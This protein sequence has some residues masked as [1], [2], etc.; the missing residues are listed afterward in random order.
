MPKRRSPAKR[1]V[2]ETV[3]NA[4]LKTIFCI[5]IVIQA[6]ASAMLAISLARLNILQP[7]QF[8]L[9]LVVLLLFLGFNIFKLLVSKRSGRA[10]KIICVII[11]ILIVIGCAAC[12]KYACQT[13]EFVE[14][15]T[16]EHHETQAYQVRALK[17]SDY[18][19]IGDI[20]GQDVGFLSVNP[21]IEKTTSALKE[22]VDFKKKTFEDVGTMIVA[23][24]DEKIAAIVLS[25]S[26]V[27][28]LEDAKNE[29]IKNSIVL[30][31]FEIEIETPDT[32]QAVDVA[33]EPFILYISGSDSRIGISE[34]ARSDVNMLAVIDPKSFKMLLVSIPRDYYVQLHGTT[35]LKDKLTH[36]G[37]YGIDM[38]KNTIQDLLKIK[39][40]YTLKVSFSTLTKLV[41]AIDG[42]EIDSDTAFYRDGCTIRQGKQQLNSACAL[43][44]SRERYS[45][46][47]GDRHRGQNQ[48]QVIA[49]IVKKITD[50]HY[51]VRY[52]DILNAIKGSFETSLSYD[53]ITSLARYQL[54][55]LR[56]WQIENISLDGTTGSAPTYSMGADRPLSVMHPDPNSV[57]AAQDKINSYL[58]NK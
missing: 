9:V 13:I 31:E 49:A 39:I 56:S 50:P 27:D 45:Y 44:Y 10:V 19:K 53:E 18:K 23:I 17:S 22:S 25:Q 35:G 52:S 51:L 14:S 48:Q 38:S 8:I 7:W 11:S 37:V 28:M 36:A 26:Y 12:Y 54:S 21:N 41:D 33:S 42:I 4:K 29:F 43:T 6:F 55:E 40:N 47:S 32:R 24:E 3:T 20:K 5:L 2:K 15:I 46:G 1:E 58:N 30:H 16:G 57:K 34:A